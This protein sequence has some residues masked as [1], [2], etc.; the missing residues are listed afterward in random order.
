ML[1]QF[2][3][4]V[5]PSGDTQEMQMVLRILASSPVS[6]VPL[7]LRHYTALCYYY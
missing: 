2:D 6:P 3:T 1:N 5:E 4:Y 7:K